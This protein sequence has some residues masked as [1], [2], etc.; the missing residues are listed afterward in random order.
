[1]LEELEFFIVS[2]LHLAFWLQAQ[3]RTIT[4]RLVTDQPRIAQ[5]RCLVISK[6]VMKFRKVPIR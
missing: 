2:Y 4:V 6:S 5:L 1:M 3:S